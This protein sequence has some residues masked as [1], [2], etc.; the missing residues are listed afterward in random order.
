MVLMSDLHLDYEYTAGNSINC[1]HPIC[2]RNDS[3]LPADPSDAAGKW[4]A[5]ACDTPPIRFENM[6]E[7]IKEEIKPDGV[8]WTGDS[9]PHNAESQTV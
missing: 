3:G 4:G 7:Y 6:M 5:Y 9:V 8:L 2:C 1:G